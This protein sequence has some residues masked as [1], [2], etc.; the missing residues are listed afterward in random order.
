MKIL[1][2]ITS[3]MEKPS[4]SWHLMKALLEDTLKAGIKVH[5]IQKHYLDMNSKAFPDSIL[6]FRFRKLM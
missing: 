2:F 1:F 6:T 4:P 5:A 3:S